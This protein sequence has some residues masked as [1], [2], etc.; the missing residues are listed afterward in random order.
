MLILLILA[1]TVVLLVLVYINATYHEAYWKKRGVVFYSKNR[2]AGPFWEYIFQDRSMFELLLDIYKDYPDA[3]AVGLGSIITPALYVRDPVNVN[4][5]FIND[6]HSF[7][8]RGITF[9]DDDKLAHNVLMLHGLKWKVIRNNIS[10][11]FTTAKLKNMYYIMDK[12]AQDFVEYLKNNPAKL[13]NNSYDTLNMFCCAAISAAVF[14]IGTKDSFESPFIQF[15]TDV[16]RPTAWSNVKFAISNLNSTIF[17]TLRMSL[18]TAQEKW[19]IS[20]MKKVIR[21]RKLENVTKHDFVDLCISLQK[22]GTMRDYDTGFEVEPT[23]EILAAQAFFF[24]LAG[25]EPCAA[26]FFAVMVELGRNIDILQEVQNEIDNTFAKHN[27]ELTYDAVVEMEYL[28]KVLNEAMRMYPPIGFLTRECI[29]E[30]VLPVGNIKVEKGTKI[31]SPIYEYHHDQQHF[32]NPEVFKPERFSGAE[33]NNGTYRPFGSGSR[34]C[35]GMRYAKL[36]IKAGIVHLLRHFT[37]R[38]LMQK[39]GIK[40]K[41]EQIQLRITNVEL[42]LLPREAH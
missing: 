25:L 37:V 31:F 3:P 28:D 16:L 26:A 12:S 40:F 29:K 17:K 9:T 14:G 33:K 2:I 11:L 39:D 41:K 20:T 13:K 1:V 5:V 24:Y 6:F 30:S 34:I 7:N 10:P 32:E 36:Q 8:H 21:E 23:D 22:K 35:V 18:F 42:E 19:F 38:T 15:V 27:N 4:H